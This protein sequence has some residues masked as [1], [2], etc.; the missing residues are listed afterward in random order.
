MKFKLVDRISTQQLHQ[1]QNNDFSPDVYTGR[2][3]L[4]EEYIKVSAIDQ[5]IV[6][7]FEKCNDLISA[8]DQWVL[9]PDK[10]LKPKLLELGTLVDEMYDYEDV[11]SYRGF[12]I[13][14]GYQNDMGLTVK[15]FFG[16]KLKPGVRPGYHFK[17]NVNDPIAFSWS[18]RIASD[19]GSV[20]IKATIPKGN[21][22]IIT[23]ELSYL[24][25]KRR[26]LNM[27]NGIATQCEIDIL[28]KA[29]I[30]CEV[31]RI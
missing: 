20:M 3:S 23:K 17:Y 12:S 30:N 27:K 14:G 15:G 18:R 22:L 1:N 4:S 9:S 28:D 6:K 11:L 31:I 2:A 26:N 24:V 19:F 5:Q 25:S 29:S 21:R 16:K 10:R 13:G 8:L 7:E